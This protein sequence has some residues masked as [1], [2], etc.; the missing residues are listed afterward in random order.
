MHELAVCQGLLRQVERVAMERGAT[1]VEEIELGIGP[2]S[3]VEADLLRRAWP[4]ACAGSIA[5]DASLTINSL[6]VRVRCDTCDCET[7]ALPNRLVCGRCGD[8]RTS[9][10][11]GDELLLISLSVEVDSKVNSELAHV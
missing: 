1:R 4:L 8:W 3:G 9:L 6:P 10:V 5:A 2:L 7:E 11:S